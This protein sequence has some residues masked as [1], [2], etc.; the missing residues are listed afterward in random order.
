MPKLAFI[1]KNKT[2]SL[3]I[4]MLPTINNNLKTLVLFVLVSFMASCVKD[5]DA[6]QPQNNGGIRESIDYTSLNANSPYAETFVD[7]NGD[8]TVNRNEGRE[9]LA[10]L[11]S[12]DATGKTGTTTELDST[13]LSSLFAPIKAMTGSSLSSDEGDVVKNFIEGFLG[14]LARASESNNEVASSGQ[15]GILTN[16]TRTYLVDQ[17]GIEWIQVISKSLM[18]AFQLDYIGNVLLDEGLDADNSTLVAGQNYTELEHNWDLAFGYLTNNDIY[19]VDGEDGE[20]FLGKYVYEYNPDGAAKIYPALLLGR[21]AIV[22][23]D[24]NAV[25][26][27]AQIIRT[28]LEKTLALAALGYLGKT[29]TGATDGANA[30]AFSEGLGFIYALR[31]C[32]VHGADAAFSDNILVYLWD[33]YWSVST[34]E[35]NNASNAIKSQFGL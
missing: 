1:F 9:A 6:P 19:G 15:A 30:H 10:Y 5:D 3:L 27:Q 25:K 35:L 34:T 21:A 20:S 28:E 8:S 18:G 26:M 23:N 4:F 33:G 22:N 31:F 14:N 32:E 7:S 11:A 2:I 16:D 29:G 24:I 17:N 12:I 13:Q